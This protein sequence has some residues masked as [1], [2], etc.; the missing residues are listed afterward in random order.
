MM[1]TRLSDTDKMPFGK[2]KG[3]PMQDV[4]ASYLHWLWT[5]Q[6]MEHDKQSAVADYIRRNKG[7]LET[8]YPDGIW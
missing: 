2:Y 7:I 4:P 6:G 1:E 3:Q 8:E 5:Q